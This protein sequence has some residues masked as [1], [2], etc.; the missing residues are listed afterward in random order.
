M[1][2]FIQSP[3][4]LNSVLSSP[5]PGGNPS[6]AFAK[7]SGAMNRPSGVMGAII[8]GIAGFMLAYQNSGGRLMGF[9]AND[10]EVRAAA[11]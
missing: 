3:S 10:E 6:P 8:G 11:K 9:V 2:L 7:I 5:S 1:T 4:F